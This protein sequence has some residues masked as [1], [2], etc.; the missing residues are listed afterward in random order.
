MKNLSEYFHILLGAYAVI[1]FTAI[2][3]PVAWWIPLIWLAVW[4]AL[5]GAAWL[6]RRAWRRRKH[7]RTV[8]AWANE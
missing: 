1:I 5:D 2:Q 3:G 4:L 7:A 8:K 6:I